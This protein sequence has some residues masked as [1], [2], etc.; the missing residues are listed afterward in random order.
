ML[1][2]LLLPTLESI[3]NR[4]LKTDP[5]AF[6]KILSLKNQV[7]KIHCNDWNMKFFMIVDSSGL[8][9]DKKYSGKINTVVTGTLNNFLHIF[10]KGAD[11]KTLF[12]YPIDIE[13]N[14]HNIEVLRDAFKNLDIDFEE[15]LSHYLGDAIA[16]K[17]CFYLKT[18]KKTMEKSAKNITNQTKEYIHYEARNL[19]SKKQME[20]FYKGVEKLR[21]DVE[22]MEAKIKNAHPNGQA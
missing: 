19:V 2:K 8:Q 9:F 3:I 11:T 4:A 12:N 15:K 6:A 16:H 7:I 20:K 5:D 21:D 1:L 14:L 22:R 10:I 18:A 13:G 17:L